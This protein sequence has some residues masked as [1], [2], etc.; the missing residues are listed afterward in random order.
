MT[1]QQ[2]TQDEIRAALS[3]ILRS[4]QL[5]DSAKLSDFLSYIVHEFSQS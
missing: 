4:R 3:I 2:P 5:A 1:G